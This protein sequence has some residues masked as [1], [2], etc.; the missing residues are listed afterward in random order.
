MK[1]LLG[2]SRAGMRMVAKVDTDR[3]DEILERD[4]ERYISRIFPGDR[5]DVRRFVNDFLA[6]G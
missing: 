6:Q 2:Q 1:K 5:N 3:Q 4:V